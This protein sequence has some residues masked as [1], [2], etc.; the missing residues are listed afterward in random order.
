MNAETFNAIR[1]A[2]GMTQMELAAYLGVHWRTVQKYGF[3]GRRRRDNN[4]HSGHP[5]P[6]PVEKLMFLLQERT[7]KGDRA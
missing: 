4:W 1:E 5:I 7:K 6:G 3:V 2:S